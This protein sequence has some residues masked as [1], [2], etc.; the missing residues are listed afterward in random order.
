MLH[1]KSPLSEAVCVWDCEMYAL[2]NEMKEKDRIRK[3]PT[4]IYG[5]CFC[6]IIFHAAGPTSGNDKNALR[7]HF[8][9]IITPTNTNCI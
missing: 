5:D 9:G 1:I 8:N 4:P 7:K 3:F 6:I 2:N